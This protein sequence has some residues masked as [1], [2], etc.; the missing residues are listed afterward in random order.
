[1]KKRFYIA[2]GGCVTLLIVCLILSILYVN[3]EP[4]VMI[5]PENMPN[6]FTQLSEVPFAGTDRASSFGKRSANSFS[7]GTTGRTSD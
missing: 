2:L 1:M 6:G 3:K 4:M 5:V 7:G